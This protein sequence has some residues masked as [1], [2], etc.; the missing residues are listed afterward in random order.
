[1]LIETE[2]EVRRASYICPKPALK[3]IGQAVEEAENLP[4]TCESM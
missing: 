3:I 2:A 4:E 1:M